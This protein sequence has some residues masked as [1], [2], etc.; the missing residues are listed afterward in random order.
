MSFSMLCTFPKYLKNGQKCGIFANGNWTWN[1]KY[2]NFTALN[3][4]VLKWHQ[5]NGGWGKKRKEKSFFDW[6]QSQWNGSNRFGI[7]RKKLL[8][9]RQSFSCQ[10][11]TAKYRIWKSHHLLVSGN[12][13]ICGP[14][15]RP[16]ILFSAFTDLQSLK[17]VSHNLL[18]A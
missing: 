12:F 13:T 10:N 7:E 1:S 15:T 6:C 9:W 18:T 4:L 16:S 17:S 14:I 5:R 8:F 3:I 2:H 11:W